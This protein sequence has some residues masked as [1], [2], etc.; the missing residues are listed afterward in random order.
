MAHHLADKMEWLLRLN[1]PA[2]QWYEQCC[3]ALRGLGRHIHSR[4]SA[5]G[6][7][8]IPSCA[9]C[10]CRTRPTDNLPMLS[11]LL[12]EQRSTTSGNRSTFTPS[13]DALV[14]C[15][16]SEELVPGE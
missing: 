16:C 8:P 14:A 5:G 7:C 1:E 12:I 9:G 15:P 11:P 6:S 3:S 4:Y 13:Q 10:S 2:S